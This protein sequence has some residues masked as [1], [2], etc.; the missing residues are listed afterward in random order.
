MLGGSSTAAQLK[1]GASRGKAQQQQGPSQQDER[2]A[3]LGGVLA[4]GGGSVK[5]GRRPLMERHSLFK[6]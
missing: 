3:R 5:Q 2:D 4:R 6:L 1:Q